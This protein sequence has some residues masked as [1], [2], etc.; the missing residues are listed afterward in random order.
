MWQQ[1]N[2]EFQ[3]LLHQVRTETMTVADLIILNEQVTQSLS[4]CND[5]DSVYV[6]RENSCQHHINQMQIRHFAEAWEQYIYVFSADHLWIKVKYESLKINEIL[7]I[8]DEEDKATEPELF[9]YTHEMPITL[10][11]NICTSLKLINK[12]KDTAAG[13]VLH[14]DSKLLILLEYYLNNMW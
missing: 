8:Q 12:A 9:L 7:E 11:V 10:L 14:S 6:T 5:L 2:L 13:I 1:K 4:L 3:N